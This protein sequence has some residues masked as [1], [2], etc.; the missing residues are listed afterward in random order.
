MRETRWPTPWR[1]LLATLRN[2]SGQD[3][4]GQ[5]SSL[6]DDMPVDI[7]TIARRAEAPALA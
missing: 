5:L 1:T 7:P 6:L 4:H 2:F 3:V